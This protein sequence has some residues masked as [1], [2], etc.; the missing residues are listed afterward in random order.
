MTK[1]YRSNRQSRGPSPIKNNFEDMVLATMAAEQKNQQEISNALKVNSPIVDTPKAATPTTATPK[2]FTPEVVTPKPDPKTKSTA[3]AKNSEAEDSITAQTGDENA[4]SFIEDTSLQL[5]SLD[6]TSK[7]VNNSNNADFSIAKAEGLETESFAT[8]AEVVRQ[9]PEVLNVNRKSTFEQPTMPSPKPDISSAEYHK[10]IV[11]ERSSTENV[12]SPAVYSNSQTGEVGPEV[13]VE[14]KP[15]KK[16]KKKTQKRKS[17]SKS[18]AGQSTISLNS[19]DSSETL[20]SSFMTENSEQFV[21]ARSSPNPSH[22]S[23][24]SDA[25]LC[26]ADTTKVIAEAEAAAP[27]PMENK[28]QDA[29]NHSKSDSI[30]SAA[31]T[32][33]SAVKSGKKSRQSHSKTDSSSTIS[34][35]SVRKSEKKSKESC[36]KTDE[37]AQPAKDDLQRSQKE[38]QP[39]SPTVNLDDPTQWPT[40]GSS[41]APLTA[42]SKSAAAPA[43]HPLS[44][45]KKNPNATIVP[46]VPLNMQPR[47]RPS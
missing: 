31:S 14:S 35:G 37:N 28:R 20:K 13:G 12:P 7:S 27:S 38:T 2:R 39:S 21:T 18:D 19:N 11:K 6:S 44:E 29:T 17:T 22:T 8:T 40:L 1:G 34:A 36:E 15:K 9:V 10:S 3:S 5:D 26:A 30:A 4:G 25:C 32:P 23:G 43:I 47:R 24:P 41:K 45:R 42:D 46:A 33:K 16:S